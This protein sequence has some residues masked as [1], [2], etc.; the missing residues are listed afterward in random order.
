MTYPHKKLWSLAHR[1]KIHF[2]LDALQ[3]YSCNCKSL[4]L[5]EKCRFMAIR[6]LK[7]GY[8]CNSP[9]ILL[10]NCQNI[11]LLSRTHLVTSGQ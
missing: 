1:N 7:N 5:A 8:F 11:F 6:V 4:I 3:N 10:E 2:I 9:S